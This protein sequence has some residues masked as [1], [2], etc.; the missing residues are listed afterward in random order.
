MNLPFPHPKLEKWENNG[1]KVKSLKTWNSQG[2]P[3]F[4]KF[5]L[6]WWRFFISQ[7][8]PFFLWYWKIWFKVFLKVCTSVKVG[9]L[10]WNDS[11]GLTGKNL[12]SCMSAYVYDWPGWNDN[13]IGKLLGQKMVD[14]I[15]SLFQCLRNCLLKI[16]CNI[17]VCGVAPVL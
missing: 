1:S 5:H 4:K 6:Q 16:F 11:Q 8:N 7:P 12:F 3:K 17:Y 15:V 10:W 14:E 13:H 9:L 2:C